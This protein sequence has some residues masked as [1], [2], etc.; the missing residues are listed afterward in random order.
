[1]NNERTELDL[2]LLNYVET[3]ATALEE[4]R[5]AGFTGNDKQAVADVLTGD[6]VP[7]PEYFP[8]SSA[9][10]QYGKAIARYVL[11]KET[12]SS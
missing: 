9:C 5:N 4:L 7:V 8:C 12:K 3:S 10:V 2:L 1:M 6:V 11:E